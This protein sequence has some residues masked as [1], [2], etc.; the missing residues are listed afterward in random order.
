MVIDG[1]AVG[2]I[3][4]I[5]PG[6]DEATRK[7]E[8]RI[9]TDDETIS[10]GDTVRIIKNNKSSQSE[11]KEVLVPLSAVKFEASDGFILQVSDGKITQKSVVLGPV[12]GSQVVV[13]EGLG[14]NDTFI[15]DVRGLTVGSEVVIAE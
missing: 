4:T 14:I 7:T 2:I 15:K 11:M 12:R 3:T 9:A 13:S 5:A 6:I 8:V 10:N 1:S